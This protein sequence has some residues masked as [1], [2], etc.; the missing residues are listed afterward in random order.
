MKDLKSLRTRYLT[1]LLL[2]AGVALNAACSKAPEPAET[3]PSAATAPAEET[4][5]AGVATAPADAIYTNGHIWIGQDSAGAADFVT[6]LAVRGNE[7][8]A[9]GTDA[10][11]RAL[12]GPG[13][14]QTDLQGK[15]VLPG[16]IDNHTHFLLSGLAMQR[17]NL[18]DAD[19]PEEFS[20]RIAEQ[21]KKQPGEWII[22]GNWDHELWG[23][24]LPSRDWI[25][26]ATP[27]TPVFVLRLDRHMALAN[28]KAL[29]LA[30][31]DD[32]VVAPDGGA[33]IRDDDGRITGLFKD[34][35][36]DLVEAV[37]PPPSDEQLDHALQAATDLAL[38]H[39]V[40]QVHDMGEWG[41]LQVFQRAKAAGELR[42][43]IHEYS[44]IGHAGE[45]A[46]YIEANGRGDELL[47]WGGV[48]GFVD[49]SLGSTT[50]WFYRPYSDAPDTSGMTMT[51]L[52]QLQQQ[53]LA[54]DAA[55]LQL[56]I[57][58]IGD[59]ANDWLLDT[60]AGI[61]DAHGPGDRRFRIEH[62][63]HLTAAAIPRFAELGVV[64]SMQPYHA[65]DDGRWAEKRIGPDRIKTTYAFRSLLDAHARLTFG[66]DWAVAP[67]NP[68]QGID[69]AVTRRTIDGLQPDGW[70]PEQ[71]ITVLQA[72]QAYIRN[73]A[74]AGFQ[75]NRL[76]R[77]APG[78]LADFVVLS[79]NIFAI[80]PYRLAD[81]EVMRTVV[82][83]KHA[84]VRD[85]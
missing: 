37:I 10:E 43:R 48:K 21:A 76:G 4:N 16:F 77:I 30:G 42:L 70:V 53:M 61:I 47:Q 79:E 57:H 85:E 59:R 50:A 2:V 64:P 36:M 80:D 51:D 67:I 45:L 5:A 12:A 33:I 31:L 15:L 40:T 75:E 19:T 23:G 6:A 38:S 60:F 24:E 39:G 63:Q 34:A 71:K 27:D 18:R 83:G 74:W 62:A 14:G 58:A 69:A 66:S 52:D 41:H 78:Y 49:G 32:S 35:A 1:G 28:S 73:N 81:V 13:T 11:I 17:I 82:D 26:A 22:E 25:D 20:R 54:A 84:Y 29:E 72:L 8:A 44:L 46:E 68:L 7:I 55:G 56:A 3:A 9:V 65:I